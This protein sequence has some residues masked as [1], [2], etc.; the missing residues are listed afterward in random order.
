M[1]GAPTEREP[2]GLALSSRNRYLDPEQRLE[3]RRS[4]APSGPRSRR[5]RTGSTRRSMPPAPSCAQRIGVDLDYLAITTSDL[6]DLTDGDTDLP[7]GT[8][9]RVLIAARV[10][11]TR[12]IDNL[13]LTLGGHES[14]CAR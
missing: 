5:R 7:P 9:G 1:V 12:L 10:G 6:V 8:E 3:A 14:C 13:P 11:T 4:T 2:D